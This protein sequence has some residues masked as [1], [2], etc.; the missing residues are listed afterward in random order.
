[1]EIT[2]EINKLVK[3]YNKNPYDINNGGCEGFMGSIIG[4]MGGYSR[5]LTCGTPD[6]DSRWPGHYWIEYKGRYYDAE[7]PNGVSDW[8]KLPIMVR[9]VP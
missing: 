4:R 5:D 6:F 8:R 7:C 3:E 2:Q 1:M 9:L